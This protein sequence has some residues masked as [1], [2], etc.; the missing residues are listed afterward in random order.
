MKIKL[1]SMET[2]GV[3]IGI[4][5][6]KK[7]VVALTERNRAKAAHKEAAVTIAPTRIRA[8][9]NLAGELK[10]SFYVCAVVFVAGRFIHSVC[11]SYETFKII[12]TATSDFGLNQKARAVFEAEKSTVLNARYEILAPP[13]ATS[14]AKL[15]PAKLQAQTNA[16]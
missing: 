5:G 14:A 2:R 3:Y 9:L 16:A 6:G 8:G 12:K 13:K 1:Q 15:S 11:V 7:A 10:V 4:I